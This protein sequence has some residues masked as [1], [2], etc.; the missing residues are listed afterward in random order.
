MKREFATALSHTLA[1]LLAFFVAAQE[2]ADCRKSYSNKVKFSMSGSAESDL[3]KNGFTVI[4][5]EK[6]VSIDLHQGTGYGK[7]SQRDKKVLPGNKTTT[8]IT[9]AITDITV[10]NK[11]KC[12][13]SIQL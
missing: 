6:G 1:F 12:N 10:M 13:G 5:D 4:V 11:Q 3:T 8:D 2:F 9:E 7:G